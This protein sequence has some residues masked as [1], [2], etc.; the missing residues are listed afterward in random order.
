M[1]QSRAIGRAVDFLCAGA[2]HLYLLECRGGKLYAGIARDVI[3]RFEQHENGKGARFTRANPPLRILGTSSFPDMSSAL[4]AEY[5]LKQL[6]RG[7]KLAQLTA[8]VA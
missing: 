6:P 7:L 2:W 5:A 3:A 4:K 8:V 1:S